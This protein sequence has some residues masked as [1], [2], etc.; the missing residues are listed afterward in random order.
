MWYITFSGNIVQHTTHFCFATVVVAAA[1]DIYYLYVSFL[2]NLYLHIHVIYL[3]FNSVRIEN[4]FPPSVTHRPS[5]Y[6]RTTFLVA[7]HEF[8]TS[9]MGFWQKKV[10]CQSNFQSPRVWLIRI[11]SIH[12]PSNHIHSHIHR[13]YAAI[14]HFLLCQTYFNLD[15]HVSACMR[16]CVVWWCKWWGQDSSSSSLMEPYVVCER[17]FCVHS[18]RMLAAAKQQQRTH[19]STSSSLGHFQIFY[20]VAHMI[21]S[22]CLSH[23]HSHVYCIQ[24]VVRTYN[25]RRCMKSKLCRQHFKWAYFTLFSASL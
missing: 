25:R 8:C 16:Q 18:C 2:T 3:C 7:K 13:Y 12:L 9:V 11:H 22:T 5:K 6:V 24:A 4:L 23:C 17:G 20:F 15:F 14:K 1:A 10:W 19:N 21:F